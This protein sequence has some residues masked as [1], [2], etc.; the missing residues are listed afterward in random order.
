MNLLITKVQE[1]LQ[2]PLSHTSALLGME[3]CGEEV[4]LVYSRAVRMD[5]V[6]HG[7]GLLA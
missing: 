7:D 4:V 6:C 1:I 5:I 2:Y 3:L